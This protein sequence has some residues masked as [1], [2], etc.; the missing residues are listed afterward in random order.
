MEDLSNCMHD[1]D[2]HA[3]AY[4][5]IKNEINIQKQKLLELEKQLNA[6]EALLFKEE[7]KLLDIIGDLNFEKTNRDDP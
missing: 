6:A 2:I 5:R 7:R 4:K 1:R 3:T